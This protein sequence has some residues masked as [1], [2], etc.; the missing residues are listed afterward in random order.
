MFFCSMDFRPAIQFDD[1]T[2]VVMNKPGVWRPVHH[3]AF[4][5]A[6]VLSEAEWRRR[7]EPEFGPLTVPDPKDVAPFEMPPDA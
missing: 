2:G 5:D 1:C 6:A 7:F 4:N 3:D